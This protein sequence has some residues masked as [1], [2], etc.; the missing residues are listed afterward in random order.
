MASAPGSSVG[1]MSACATACAIWQSRWRAARDNTLQNL[2]YVSRRRFPR[3]ER[4]QSMRSTGGSPNE[5]PSDAAEWPGAARVRVTS[6]TSHTTLSSSVK[7]IGTVANAPRGEGLPDQGRYSTCGSVH[8]TASLSARP[9]RCVRR[10]AG[11]NA[12]VA[13]SSA[14]VSGFSRSSWTDPSATRV[15]VTEGTVWP[16]MCPPGDGAAASHESRSRPRTNAG[17]RTGHS[18]G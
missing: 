15:T 8:A 13:R 16:A 4:K 5:G 6:H 7:L 3:A 18:L 17:P 9:P 1:R 10:S 12:A 11:W 14:M 2:G